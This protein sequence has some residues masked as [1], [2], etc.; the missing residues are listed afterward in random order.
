MTILKGRL[1]ALPASFSPK[2]EIIET[3]YRRDRMVFRSNIKFTRPGKRLH[4]VLERSTMLSSWVNPLFLSPF[5]I[6]MLN[7]QRVAIVFFPYG[8]NIEISW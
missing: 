8:I 2:S 5:S 1:K 6:A 4:S 7:Y 3:I